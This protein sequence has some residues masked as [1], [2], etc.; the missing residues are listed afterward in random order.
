MQGVT[1]PPA[2]SSCA[3]RG[4]RRFSNQPAKSRTYP[5]PATSLS[6]GTALTRVP[7]LQ[8]QEPVTSALPPP[9]AG[10]GG[11]LAAGAARSA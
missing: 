6:L 3:C 7:P 5:P 2:R 4:R 8:G 1:L 10:G 11:G 9:L